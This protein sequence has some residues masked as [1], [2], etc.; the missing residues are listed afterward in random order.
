MLAVAK[1]QWFY[2]LRNLPLR[3]LANTLIWL[4]RILPERA[5]Y[6]LGAGLAGLLWWLLPRWRQTAV[7]NLELV[8]G[9]DYDPLERLRIGHQAARH[10]GWYAI[11]F[12]RMGH[13]PVERTL[14][15]ISEVEGVG[16]VRSALE[17]GR[18]AMC[19]SMHYGNWDLCGAYLTQS[20][21]TL[22]AVG[23]PQRDEFFSRLAFP[24]RAHLGIV[25]IMSGTRM[26]SAILRVLKDNNVLGLVADQNGGSTGVF[27]PFAGIPASTVPGPAALALKF[28]CPLVVCYTRRLAP[29]KHRW[30]AKPALDMAGLPADHDE[31]MVEVLTRINNAYVEV[32]REDPSQWLL[33]H[34]RFKTRP[35][36]EPWLY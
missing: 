24:W 31:A 29:G 7:R 16:H 2:V 21:R 4:V 11:E 26:N 28:G 14:A 30:V 34:K 6:G 8:F 20:I 33:G 35:A 10:L 32:I 12:I 23:K 22:H 36:G 1:P 5:A 27:A 25:N 18:G 3:V 19:L 9:E 13:V 17:Q 15:M